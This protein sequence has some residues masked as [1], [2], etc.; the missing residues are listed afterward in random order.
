MSPLPPEFDTLE[1]F[2]PAQI[3]FLR[4]APNYHEFGSQRTSIDGKN[5]HL[6][7]YSYDIEGKSYTAAQI[8]T[9][10]NNQSYQSYMLRYL[11]PSEQFNAEIGIAQKMFSSFHITGS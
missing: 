7:M 1:E 8:W 4:G 6:I 2:T 3:N 9:I 10:S 5:A 11:A